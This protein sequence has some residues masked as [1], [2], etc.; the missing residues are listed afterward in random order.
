MAVNWT[1]CVNTQQWWETQCIIT[2]VSLHW[3]RN[4]LL[5]DFWLLRMY[6][7]TRFTN[8]LWLGKGAITWWEPWLPRQIREGCVEITLFWFQ[9]CSGL[10]VESAAVDRICNHRTHNAP[11]RVTSWTWIGALCEHLISRNN[12]NASQRGLGQSCGAR[13]Y[14]VATHAD[15][16]SRK[17]ITVV[18][19][20]SNQPCWWR[21]VLIL[22]PSSVVAWGACIIL[23]IAWRW[24]MQPEAYIVRSVRC[25]GFV[26]DLC[27]FRWKVVGV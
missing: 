11:P 6:S 3:N 23:Y 14:S 13:Q 25:P 26:F 8:N 24:S 4:Q 22:V 1:T 12:N 20:S 10:V 2:A 9:T 15:D 21:V 5:L 18:I 17:E 16:T 19:Q 7:S 27:K